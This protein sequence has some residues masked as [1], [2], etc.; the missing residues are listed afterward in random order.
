MCAY[1]NVWAQAHLDT[2]A[3]KL[4][5]PPA[6][7]ARLPT[8]PWAGTWQNLLWMG[9]VEGVISIADFL[10]HPWRP[11]SLPAHQYSLTAFPSESVGTMR[12]VLYQRVSVATRTAPHGTGLPS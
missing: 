10:G 5:K 9:M 2:G 1:C 6:Q 11:R 4:H 8:A 3:G 12:S 7:P